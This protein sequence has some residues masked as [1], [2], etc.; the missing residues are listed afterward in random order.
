MT[1]WRNQSSAFFPPSHISRFSRGVCCKSS[2]FN[3]ILKLFF[4]RLNYSLWYESMQTSWVPLKNLGFYWN[5]QLRDESLNSF[6]KADRFCSSL[7]LQIV[8]HLKRPHL[9]SNIFMSQMLA[10][11]HSY[12]SKPTVGTRSYQ[13]LTVATTSSLKSLFQS[14]QHCRYQCHCR[15]VCTCLGSA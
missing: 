9:L 14:A 7:R 11:Q 13:F 2:I 1:V 4:L 12:A 5:I 8:R 3:S 15:S 6:A 10:I